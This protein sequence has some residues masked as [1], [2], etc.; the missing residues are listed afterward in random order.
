MRT[1]RRKAALIATVLIA[2]LPVVGATAVNLDTHYSMTTKIS[3]AESAPTL[4][5][6]PAYYHDM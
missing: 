2:S 3:A 1:K 6:A 5:A 4:D